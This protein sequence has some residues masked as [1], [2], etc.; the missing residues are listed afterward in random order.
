[1]VLHLVKAELLLPHP[2]LPNDGRKIHF[3]SFRY[4]ESTGLNGMA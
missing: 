1:M 2:Y 3:L 4:S